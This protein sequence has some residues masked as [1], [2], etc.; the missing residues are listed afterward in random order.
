MQDQVILVDESD[1][2][3]GVE[4]KLKAHREGK[5]HRAFSI[6][7][8]NSKDELL[9][10]RRAVGK[11]HSGGLWSN[12]CCSHP[13][14]SEDTAQAAARR[15]VEE[16][17]LSCPLHKAFYFT[18]KAGLEG[19][20]V[21]HEFDHVFLGYFNGVA[22]PDPNE[23]MAHRWFPTADLEKSVQ[24]HPQNYTPWFRIA[25]ARAVESWNAR[26]QELIASAKTGETGRRN[27]S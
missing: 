18:Y 6:F 2:Q 17:G 25:L 3:I 26:K 27:Q 13:R 8:F 12:T 23:V 11:Y 10:Q 9:M 5:L 15:L 16:M 1:R 4:D 21:E 19:G 20:L 22:Y 7:L 14:P 24:T